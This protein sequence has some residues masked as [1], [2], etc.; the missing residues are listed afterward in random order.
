MVLQVQEDLLAP[1]HHFVD[2]LGAGGGEELAADLEQAHAPGQAVH[3]DARLVRGGH[4]EGDDQTLLR[5]HT[6][7]LK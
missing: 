1:G 2:D 3:Q 6:A 4:V 5:F 7:L